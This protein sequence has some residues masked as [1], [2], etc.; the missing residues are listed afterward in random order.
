[1]ACIC[2]GARISNR[3]GYTEIREE[4]LRA[5]MLTSLDILRKDLQEQAVDLTKEDNVSTLLGN[6]LNA[7]RARNTLITNVIHKGRGKPAAGSVKVL[8]D[9]SRLEAVHVHVGLEDKMMHINSTAVSEWCRDKGISRQAFVKALDKQY[10][11]RSIHGRIGGGTSY[12]VSELVYM[13]EI[14][15]TDLMDNA[16]VEEI[17]S[18]HQTGEE[19]HTNGEIKLDPITPAPVLTPG[20]GT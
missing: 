1:M 3:L 20:N 9:A 16:G 18:D 15:M 4:E 5:F 8:G 10:G 12:S 17:F 14:H 6:F 19:Q 2:V 13:L 11:A 7:K